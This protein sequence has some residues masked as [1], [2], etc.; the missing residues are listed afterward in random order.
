MVWDCY[1]QSQMIKSGLRI[2]WNCNLFMTVKKMIGNGWKCPICTQ[3]DQL[4]E[5]GAVFTQDGWGGAWK[6]ALYYCSRIVLIFL[7]SDFCWFFLSLVLWRTPGLTVW[8][9]GQEPWN[10]LFVQVNVK[11]H[12]ILV[13]RTTFRRF[14]HVSQAADE[15]EAEERAGW[16]SL[17]VQWLQSPWS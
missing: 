13:P 8:A 4:E 12:I 1:K 17:F 6:E 10:N 9:A 7:K 11:C 15:A 14:L 2:T 3:A 5:S 16:D